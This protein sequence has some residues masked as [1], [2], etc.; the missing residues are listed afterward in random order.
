MTRVQTL[1]KVALAAAV[2]SGGLL[3]VSGLSYGV[4][5]AEARFARWMIGELETPVPDATGWYGGRRLGEV[6]RVALLGD[7][8]AAGYGVETVAETTGAVL[9]ASLSERSDRRVYLREF[10]KVGA[11][12]PDLA[13]QVTRAL[14]LRPHVAVILIGAND[15]THTI[16]PKES[17]RAL[18]DAVRRLR[19]VG[20]EV[21]VGTCPDLGTVRPIPQPLKT[22]ARVWSR[23]LAADQSAATLAEGGRSVSLGSLLGP[24]FDASPQVL[25]GPDRFHPSA[26]GYAAC[27]RALLPTVL[28]AVGVEQADDLA[29]T[30]SRSQALE[31]AKDNPG[32]ELDP[33]S[34]GGLVRVF[35]RRRQP[36]AAPESPQPE[37]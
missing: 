27:V 17:I 11:T 10:C 29:E 4:L 31:T 5:V 32:T 28:S 15:V 16:L 26:I 33:A 14:T 37:E 8:S 21:V 20:T 2:G 7:S 24:E 25:F 36:L 23:R 3:G 1:R 6:L 34:T 30:M 9:A 13:G 22:V 18:R 35:F 12:T 19:A